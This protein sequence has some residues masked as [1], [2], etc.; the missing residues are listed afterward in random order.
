MLDTP[1]L[2]GVIAAAGVEAAAADGDGEKRSSAELPAPTIQGAVVPAAASDDA[3]AARALVDP[4]SPASVPPTASPDELRATAPIVA[5]SDGQAALELSEVLAS[6]S[7][8]SPAPPASVAHSVAVDPTP[9]D[10]VPPAAPATPVELSRPMPTLYAAWSASLDD[11][12]KPETEAVAVVVV[13]VASQLAV[14]ARVALVG[15]AEGAAEAQSLAVRMS[16]AASALADIVCSSAV[17]ETRVSVLIGWC[18]SRLGSV[19]R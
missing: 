19:G 5:A 17:A 6:A 15:D 2:G 18:V 1:S 10:D 11:S 3:S 14:E 7:E 8:A 16:S 13:P 9:A 12:V 4:A